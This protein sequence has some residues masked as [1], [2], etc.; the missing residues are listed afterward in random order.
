MQ[1]VLIAD[2][3]RDPW[4]HGTPWQRAPWRRA[5]QQALHAGAAART[6]FVAQS[7]TSQSRNRRTVSGRCPRRGR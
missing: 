6:T 7:A 2:I 3:P 5:D 4:P 1:I